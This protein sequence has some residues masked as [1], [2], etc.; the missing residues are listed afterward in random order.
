MKDLKIFSGNSNLDLAQ[1]ICD[2][3]GLPLG[4]LRVGR[5][6]DGE[7]NV[8][9]EEDVR[10]KD[11]FIIQSTCPPVNDNLMELLIVIDAFRRAS[12]GRITAVIPYYGYARQDRKAEGRVPISAK[13]VA[14]LITVAGADRI[15][16]MDLHAGQI[17]G[18]FDIPVDH[19]QSLPIIVDYLR[20]KNIPNLVVV[21]PD[22]GAVKLGRDY[23]KKL[24]TS[25]CIVEKR[26]ENATNTEVL[27][28]I[29]IGDVKHKNILVVDD[30]ISTG[31]SLIRAIEFL[32]KAEI[33]DI[34]I[35]VTH[36]VL[37]DNSL[38]R[39]MSLNIKEAIFTN[40]IP[41]PVEKMS[42][43]NNV[44]IVDTSAIFSEVIKRIH[45][46]ESVSA[47]FSE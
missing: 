18:F 20:K 35:A 1:R 46:N 37:V 24:N 23:A 6:A 8:K 29:G 4:L 11:V 7:V 13:L 38:H 15:L 47:I 16:T 43:Y 28:I 32:K 12:A 17:Q 30:M 19:L 31:T 33:N 10:G 21:S 3:L 2:R 40:T 25:L 42:G 22:L 36:P 45:K 5:F 41:I 27:N 14:N 39:L 9:I 26:R 44:T 34:Y